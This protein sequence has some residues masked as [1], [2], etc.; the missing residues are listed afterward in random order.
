MSDKY[1]IEYSAEA[2]K[3]L[4]KIYSYI[5]VNLKVPNTARGQVN[6]IRKEIRSLEFM[7]LRY[8][9]VDWEP[10]KN[11]EMHK[12][13]ADNYVIYYLVNVDSHTVEIVRICYAGQDVA[14]AINS[15]N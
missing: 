15:V 5:A 6:R 14:N 9:E 1:E 3:D 11:M 2:L 4:R 7:P 8:A 10:W 13:L 12:S